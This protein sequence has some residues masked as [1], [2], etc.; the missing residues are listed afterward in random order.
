MEVTP[1]PRE[2]GVVNFMLGFFKIKFLDLWFP[3]V[4]QKASLFLNLQIL[5]QPWKASAC[6]W[7]HALSLDPEEG[8]WDWSLGPL[9]TAFPCPS[10]KY[11]RSLQR[12]SSTVGYSLLEAQKCENEEAE[13]VTA[14]ASLSVG[15]KHAEK[16][17][18]SLLPACFLDLGNI[19][20]GPSQQ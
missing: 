8:S 7:Q 13:T 12:F 2:G 10:G 6:G 15:V 1:S 17:W 14:L 20:A 3:C 11:W 4:F 5:R 19:R 9:T 18:V 16:R